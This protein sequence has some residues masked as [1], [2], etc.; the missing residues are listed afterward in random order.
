MEERGNGEGDSGV[1][2]TAQSEDYHA[3]KRALLE[4]T[5]EE[6]RRQ[7]EEGNDYDPCQNQGDNGILLTDKSNTR[8]HNEIC[9]ENLKLMEETQTQVP[10]KIC[11]DTVSEEASLLRFKEDFQNSS[12]NHGSKERADI[13]QDNMLKE[14]TAS[15]IEWRDEETCSSL[16]NLLSGTYKCDVQLTEAIFHYFSKTYGS[17]QKQE[18]KKYPETV[19]DASQNIVAEQNRK[20]GPVQPMQGEQEPS[21]KATEDCNIPDFHSTKELNEHLKSFIDV[22][23][24]FNRLEKMMQQ[25][26]LKNTDRLSKSEEEE[27]KS[28]DS[29]VINEGSLQQNENIVSNE[30]SEQGAPNT[31]PETTLENHVTTSEMSLQGIVLEYLKNLPKQD[32]IVRNISQNL[33][34]FPISER[35]NQK[36]TSEKNKELHQTLSEKLQEIL[37]QLVSDHLCKIEALDGQQKQ[38]LN[39]IAQENSTNGQETQVKFQS[40]TTHINQVELIDDLQNIANKTSEE[41]KYLWKARA[42]LDSASLS[43]KSIVDKDPDKIEEQ[44][45]SLDHSI[46]PVQGLDE[47]ILEAPEE[48]RSPDMKPSDHN[49]KPMRAEAVDTCRRPPPTLSNVSVGETT[50]IPETSSEEVHSMALLST[51]QRLKGTM[52]ECTE[53]IDGV[54]VGVE[55]ESRT[56]GCSRETDVNRDR[57][58]APEQ[59]TDGCCCCS[60]KGSSCDKCD[61]SGVVEIR[62]SSPL[63]WAFRNGRLVFVEEEEEV[64]KGESEDGKEQEG[65]EIIHSRELNRRIT[66]INTMER[67]IRGKEFKN[68]F[69][70]CLGTF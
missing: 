2:E 9:K 25:L 52:A 63:R 8:G 20:G 48:F 46:E 67:W 33:S 30:R 62:R 18:Q 28:C 31:F 55:R 26:V 38:N 6:R 42:L 13:E 5:R 32:L 49:N 53:S 61:S 15:H 45:E 54:G 39:E 68:A 65:D 40:T 50:P 64:E 4:L 23:Q 44:A 37:Q 60:A 22:T 43:E 29:E 69:K 57:T 12:H 14:N 51:L 34:E 21:Q 41:A 24:R 27:H 66:G 7:R 11:D 35:L 17:H 58:F 10:V 19:T 3:L 36:T 1:K 70:R 59:K 47:T 56:P 16:E